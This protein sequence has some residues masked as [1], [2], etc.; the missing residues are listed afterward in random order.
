MKRNTLFFILLA[1]IWTVQACNT[2]KSSKDHSGIDDHAH[3]DASAIDDD[4]SD[5]IMKAASGGMMEVQLGEMAK[6]NSRSE[7]VKNFGIMMVKDHSKANTELQKLASEKNI[8]LPAV[9]NEDHQKHINELTPLRGA[10]FDE[11]YM[12]LMLH[13]HKEDI[14]LFEKAAENSDPD[15][16][17]FASATLPVLKK[18]WEAA[19]KI[20]MNLT[21]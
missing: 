21:M 17:A 14:D 5:F 9:P 6:L 4:I 16:S 19:R 11:K 12:A 2:N 7:G 1:V 10:E 8:I 18:H 13:D 15:V 3:S 20:E